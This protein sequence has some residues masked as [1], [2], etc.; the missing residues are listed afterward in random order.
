MPDSSVEEKPAGSLREQW[1]E[2]I[3]EQAGSGLSIKQYCRDRGLAEHSF[4][5]WRKRLRE[6]EPVRFALVDHTGAPD[7]PEWNLEL[8][9][10]SG[11]RLRIGAGVD[12]LTLRTVLEALRT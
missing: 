8:T 6:T 5:G 1:R 9:L 3:V 11:E 10:L 7:G 4:Y 2:R 12:G